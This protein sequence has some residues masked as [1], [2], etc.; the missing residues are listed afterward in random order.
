VKPISQWNGSIDAAANT[1]GR[2]DSP[3]GSIETVLKP[4]DGERR[5][6]LRGALAGSFQAR[7]MMTAEAVIATRTNRHIATTT[8]RSD[9]EAFMG[10]SSEHAIPVQ[11]QVSS[12]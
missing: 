4:F 3:P 1:A 7:F 12:K 8:I 10:V 6:G 5:R 11:L 2:R 9:R